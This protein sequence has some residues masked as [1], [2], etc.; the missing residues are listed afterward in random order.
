MAGFSPVT[1]RAGGNENI[2]ASQVVDNVLAGPA[3]QG[4]RENMRRTAGGE[5]FQIGDRCEPLHGVSLQQLHM[6]QFLRKTVTAQLHRLGKARDLSGGL[7]SGAQAAL[8]SA[9]GQ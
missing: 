7:R 6:A 9:A 2:L 8:L 1:G 3:L 5:N 4:N